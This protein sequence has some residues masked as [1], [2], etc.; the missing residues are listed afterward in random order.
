MECDQ[1]AQRLRPGGDLRHH[2]RPRHRHADD[3]EARLKDFVDLSHIPMLTINLLQALPKTPLW[4]RLSAR[5]PARRRS[6]AREQRAL[7]AALRRGGRRVAPLHRPCLRSGAAV[8][9]L[10]A[11]GR[12]HLSEPDDPAGARQAHLGQPIRARSSLAFRD[13]AVTSACCRTTAAVL[14]GGAPCAAPRPDRRGVRHGASS[15]I[16]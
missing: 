7:P 1:D 12:R 15:A 14:A 8:R 16:T 13:R 5:E 6:D 3:T 10:Q 9:A 11:P 4:D 2:P